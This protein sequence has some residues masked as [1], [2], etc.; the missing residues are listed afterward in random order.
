VAR[1]PLDPNNC[2]ERLAALAAPERLRIIH[3]LRTGP[4]NATEI[5][6]MLG[7]HPV[8]V[9]HHVKV[10]TAAGLIQREKRGRFVI[11]SL[12]PSVLE[13]DEGLTHLNLGCC[14]LELP[15]EAE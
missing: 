6:E 14:R 8:N 4:H 1:H 5:A 9:S 2:A 15:R 12:T 7:T 3:F 11:F 13:D 10:L